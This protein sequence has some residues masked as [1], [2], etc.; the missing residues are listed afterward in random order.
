MFSQKIELAC[1]LALLTD[2]DYPR[3]LFQLSTSGVWR[4]CLKVKEKSWTPE[5]WTTE[6]QKNWYLGVRNDGQLKDIRW[7]WFL[8]LTCMWPVAACCTLLAPRGDACFVSSD[9]LGGVVLSVVRKLCCLAPSLELAFSPVPALFLWVWG[10]S[11]F[12][13]SEFHFCLEWSE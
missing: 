13:C 1:I 7:W 12:G 9:L 5:C 4:H 3:D 11:G 10:R 2:P 6:S 8:L